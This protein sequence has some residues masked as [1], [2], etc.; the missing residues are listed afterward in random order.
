MKKKH[1]LTWMVRKHHDVPVT[2]G[3]AEKFGHSAC[4]AIA[5]A[6]I[7][8]VDGG[9]LA[10]NMA[11]YDGKTRGGLASTLLFRVWISFADLLANSVDLPPGE[12]DLCRRVAAMVRGE[13]DEPAVQGEW[14]NDKT[15]NR[16]LN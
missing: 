6:A 4:D 8:H 5:V 14:V 12:R 1:P 16:V 3:D 10:V 15:T 2:Q 11:T 9:G 7:T 13:N